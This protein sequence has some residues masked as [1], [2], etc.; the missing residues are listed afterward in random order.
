MDNRVP[1]LDQCSAGQ[2]D[3]TKVLVLVAFKVQPLDAQTT[4]ALASFAGAPGELLKG[5]M[6]TDEK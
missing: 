2:W 6:H 4:A 1:P 3:K 5:Q